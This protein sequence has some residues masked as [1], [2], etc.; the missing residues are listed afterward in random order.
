MLMRLQIFSDYQFI[1]KI[2]IGSN[3]F[4]KVRKKY[5]I[6]T[7]IPDGKIKSTL[8]AQHTFLV[9]SSNFPRMR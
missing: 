8:L 3:Y 9:P 7:Y 4:W 6:S 5:N 1:R 2:K